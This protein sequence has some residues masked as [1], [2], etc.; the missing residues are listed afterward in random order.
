[1]DVVHHHPCLGDARIRAEYKALEAM[2]ARKPLHRSKVRSDAVFASGMGLE[3][4]G[5]RPD[6]YER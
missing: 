3:A 4:A 1:M 5:R 6:D 2:A